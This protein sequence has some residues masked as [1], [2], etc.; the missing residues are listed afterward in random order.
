MQP[1]L[2]QQ[3]ARTVNL[4]DIGGVPVAGGGT[5]KRGLL[6]RSATLVGSRPRNGWR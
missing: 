3:L 4:R 6:Y 5:V 2:S 1:S